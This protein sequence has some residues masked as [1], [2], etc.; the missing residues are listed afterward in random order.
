MEG[1]ALVEDLAGITFGVELYVPWDTPD[2]VV[3]VHSEGVVPL[4]LFR[5]LLVWSAV[6]R[7]RRKVVFCKGGMSTVYVFWFLIR[8]D[9]IRTFMM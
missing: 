8:V 6:G 2:T 4:G 9:W 3:D 5:T 7:T 1:A